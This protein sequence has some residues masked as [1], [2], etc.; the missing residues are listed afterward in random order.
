[1]FGFSGGFMKCSRFLILLITSVALLTG[2]AKATIRP[3]GGDRILTDR[4]D[5]EESESFFLWGIAGSAKVNLNRVCDG[6]KVEQMQ[7]QFAP[8]DTFLWLLTGGIYAPK[9]ARVWCAK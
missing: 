8:V 1:M 9:T 4:A 2:C 6:K 3:D 5:Y 7:T